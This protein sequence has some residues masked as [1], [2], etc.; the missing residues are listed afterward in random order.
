MVVGSPSTCGES[1]PIAAS[2]L[3][4][5][6]TRSCCATT[7][8]TRALTSACCAFS[9]SRVVRWPTRGLLAHA[10]E[11][12]VGG[13][14]LRLRGDDLGLGRLQLAPRLHHRLPGLVADLIE[15]EALLGEALLGL[16]DQREFAAALVDRDRELADDRRAQLVDDRDLRE[17][18]ILHGPRLRFGNSAP[19]LILTCR[20]ATSTPYI[21]AVTLGFS[22]SPVS[23]ATGSTRGEKRSTGEPGARLTGSV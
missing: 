9:T 18:R 21:A 17:A 4:E 22:A 19:S 5:A 8:A 12:H 16:A 15:I 23:I 7:S 13:S 3:Y 11:R 6:T 2:R 14:D 1:L 20:K 10:V